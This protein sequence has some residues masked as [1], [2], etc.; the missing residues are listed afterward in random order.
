LLDVACRSYPNVL[1]SGRSRALRPISGWVLICAVAGWA[2]FQFS[3][4]F[5]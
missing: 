5:S 3:F 2:K 1:I 4:Q